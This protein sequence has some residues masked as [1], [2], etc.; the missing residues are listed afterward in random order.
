M[1]EGNG[2]EKEGSDSCRNSYVNMVKHMLK[3]VVDLETSLKTVT[4]KKK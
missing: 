3:I 4:S 1:N 2:W